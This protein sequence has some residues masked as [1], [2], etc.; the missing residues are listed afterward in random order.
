MSEIADIPRSAGIQAMLV[1]LNNASV[2]ETSLMDA[3]KFAAMID[4]AAVATHVK[5]AAGFLLAFDQTSTYDGAHFLWFRDRLAR[6]LYVDRVVISAAVRRAGLGRQ[7]YHDLFVRAARMG[8]MTVTCE[9]N[10]APPNPASD[11]FHAQLGF[12]PAGQ[13]TVPGSDKAVRYLVRHG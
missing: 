2:L 3:A 9:V 4:A 7:L 13:A 12:Q 10:L 1:A 8:V 6:F 11:A 5:P